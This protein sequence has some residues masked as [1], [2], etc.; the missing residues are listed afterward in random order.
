MTMNS[1]TEAEDTIIPLFGDSGVEKAPV[2]LSEREKRG[3]L[4]D[5]HQFLLDKQKLARVICTN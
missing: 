5:A 3:Q 2:G 4:I 1:V